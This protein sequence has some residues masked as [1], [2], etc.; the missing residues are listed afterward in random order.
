ME[1]VQAPGTTQGSDTQ[2]GSGGQS[3]V[4]GDAVNRMSQAAGDVLDQAKS[5]G[6]SLA[7]VASDTAKDLLGQRIAVGGEWIGHIAETTKSAADTLQDKSPEL[8]GLV[9]QAGENIENLS[10]QLQHSSVD[11]LAQTAS[12]FARR[13]P[14]VVFGVSAVLAFVAFR[15]FSGGVAGAT[16]QA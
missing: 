4:I 13:R 1:N 10:N 9:R 14:E 3:G 5:K 11:E 16:R 12:E 6:G 8:A 2:S 7:S 15:V